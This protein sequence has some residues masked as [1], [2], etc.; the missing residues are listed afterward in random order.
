MHIVLDDDDGAGA[1]DLAQQLGGFVRFPASV[2]AG[3][4]FVDQA[5]AA[6]SWASS[7]PISSHCFWPWAEIAGR[8]GWRC[9]PRRVV[10]EQPLDAVALLGGSRGAPQGE[11]R[12]PV[13]GPARGGNCP[14]R[15][16]GSKTVGF[17]NF[18]PMPSFGDGGFVHGG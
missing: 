18:R 9:S 7:M 2:I 12:A 11:A 15:C 10:G 4:G 5:E 14:R 6:V 3:D 17:W 13:A 1:V 16:A 8:G